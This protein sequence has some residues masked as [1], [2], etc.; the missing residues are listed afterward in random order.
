MEDVYKRQGLPST[1]SA[2]MGVGQTYLIQFAIKIVIA[3]VLLIFY[4]KVSEKNN[5][6]WTIVAVSYTHLICGI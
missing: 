6:K 2:Y 5:R 1:Q 3:V 4:P